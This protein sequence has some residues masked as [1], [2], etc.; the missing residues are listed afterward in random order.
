[1][2][3][4]SLC[5]TVILPGCVLCHSVWG[6]RV[7]I[8]VGLAFISFHFHLNLYFLVVFPAFFSHTELNCISCTHTMSINGSHMHISIGI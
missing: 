3:C 7:T 8:F 2:K 4:V 5:G 1:M 6:A